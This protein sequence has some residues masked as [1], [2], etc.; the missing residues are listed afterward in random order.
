MEPVLLSIDPRWAAGLFLSLTRVGGFVVASP[1]TRPFPPVGRLAFTIGVATAM[2]TPVEAAESLS[3]LLG[4]ALVNAALGLALGWLT[5]VIFQLFSV[6]GGIVDFGSGLSV[7]QVFDP[8]SGEPAA[9]FGRWFPMTAMALFVVSGGL[10]LVL[11]GLHRSVRAI[12][13]DGGIRFD[14]DLVDHAALQVSQLMVVGVELALP[15]AA[16][17]LVCEVL[18]GMA[19]RLV[20]QFNVFLLGLPAKIWITLS[21][22]TI[23]ILRFPEVTLN[24][25]DLID[26]GF[27][28]AL[29][30][31]LPR[32]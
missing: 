2:T 14:A 12:P 13:L 20:P 22:L 11:A 24:V 18:L 17:L 3:R 21:L 8:S 26:A 23:L 5:G 1:L 9:I 10:P 28:E 6:T 32:G 30:G 15:L 16:T 25:I 19:S 27:D 4:S 29:R 31:F 7:S